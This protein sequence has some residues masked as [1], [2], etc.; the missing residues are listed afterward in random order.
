MII[1]ITIL[2]LPFEKEMSF[3]PDHLE[4]IYSNGFCI[5]EYISIDEFNFMVWNT[6][7]ENEIK[8]ETFYSIDG[9]NSVNQTNSK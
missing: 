1:S 4:G 7:P 6:L 5:D 2:Y 3:I 8:I 9:E